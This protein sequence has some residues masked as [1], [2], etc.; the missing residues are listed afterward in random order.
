M[1]NIDNYNDY[2]NESE[3]EI[4]KYYNPITKQTTKYPFRFKTEEEMDRDYRRFS[5]YGETGWRTTSY[6]FV[7]AMDYLLGQTF[8]TYPF[9][10]SSKD[11][12]I[13]YEEWR[14]VSDMLIENEK[15][16]PNYSSKKIKRTL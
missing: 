4:K 10:R 9:F 1:K 14:I 15:N 6:H 11:Y 2:V 5:S 13:I 16:V 7:S 12:Y 3:T 8:E